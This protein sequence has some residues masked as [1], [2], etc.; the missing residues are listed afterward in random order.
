MPRIITLFSVLLLSGCA[1][2]AHGP[3]QEVAIASEPPG[4]L[5]FRGNNILGVTPMRGTFTRREPGIVLRIEK[6]GYQSVTVPLDRGKSAWLAADAAMGPMQFANQGLSSSSQMATTAIIAP[7]ILLGIDF[8]TGSAYS[9][10]S[11]VSVVL[12][13]ASAGSKDPASA[14][15]EPGVFRPRQ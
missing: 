9:L 2:L 10:P 1:T 15:P 3:S 8:A 6:Q 7:S 5:V 11:R 4:A 12:K 14:N 13:P